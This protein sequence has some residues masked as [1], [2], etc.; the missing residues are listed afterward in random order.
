MF[1]EGFGDNIAESFCENIAESGFSHGLSNSDVR[2][3]AESNAYFHYPYVNCT[4]CGPRFSIIKELPYDRPFTTMSAFPMC[5]A[6]ST[7]Y[8]HPLD[9]RFH[10]QPVACRQCGPNYFLTAPKLSQ[11]SA[12]SQDSKLLQASKLS[13][14]SEPLQDSVS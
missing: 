3:L 5:A 11:D 13:Q 8:E 2:S 7:S 4:N 1:A 9:R 10:A 12:L 14:D 6:C